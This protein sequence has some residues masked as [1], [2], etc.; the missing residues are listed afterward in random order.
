[1]ELYAAAASRAAFLWSIKKEYWSNSFF[2]NQYFGGLV[3][4]GIDAD[5]C[6]ERNILQG[7][8]EYAHFCTALTPEIQQNFFKI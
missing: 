7:T 1:M 2:R 4:G 8:T 3:L 5:F 6:I